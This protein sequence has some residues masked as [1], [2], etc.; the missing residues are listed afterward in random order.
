MNN[1]LRTT[2]LLAA[3]TGL[4]VWIGQL[5]GGSQGA[6]MALVLAA[7]MNFGSYWFSDRI[8]IAMYGGREIHEQD[9]PE[10]YAIVKTLAQQNQMPVPRL[11]LIPTESPNAFATGRNPQH[12][13]VAVTAGIRRLL[14]R[15][16]LQGVLAHEL[17]HVTNRD[18]LISSIAATL[19]GAI[20]M[21]ARMAQ[22][23]MIFGGGRRDDR[24]DGGGAL[25]LL[26]TMIVAPLAAML[27]QMAI[28]RSRE[29]QADDTGARLVRD[30]EAL[31]SA[32]RKI[33]GG[34]AAVP[35]DASPQTAHMFIINPLRASALQNLFSTHPPLEE[36]LERL[37][38]IAAELGHT[39]G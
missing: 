31:A 19:A 16:E 30:P 14:T 37:Q 15:R 32:L 18:I 23:A 2:V 8:V 12:A 26:V 13:A 21:L 22:W 35:L 9:D 25:G 6:V 36:R 4:I 38:R 29:F 3:L 33:A 5:L 20:M 17:A 7:V 11:F 27:I 39:A 24:E 28:S 34:S 10:L 1:T